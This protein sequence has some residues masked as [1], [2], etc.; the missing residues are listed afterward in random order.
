[1]TTPFYNEDHRALQESVR[2]CVQ[3]ELIPNLTKWE[4]DQWFP[5]DVFKILGQAGFLGLMIPEDLGGIGGGYRMAAAWCEEFGRVPAVGLTTAVNMHS[6]VILPA[7]ARLGS[8]AAKERWIEKGLQGQAIGA[9]A[10]TEPGAGSDLSQAKTKAVKDGDS[11]VLDGSKIFITN[12]A[13]AAFVLVLA[14]TDPSAGY[15]G[16]TTFIVDTKTPGFAVS[17]KLEK[18]GW[19]S[20]DTAE[21]SFSGV[22]VHESMVLGK[23][24]AGWTQA[25]QSLEWE[26]LML[27]LN[28]LGGSSACMEATVPYINYR[29]AF[30]KPI[31]AFGSTRDM[32]ADLWARWQAGRALTY[33]CIEMLE[34][35]T[36]CRRE[37]SLAKYAVCELAI[38][39]ADRCLQLHGGYGYT[40]E[41]IPERWLR[42]LRLNTIGGGT[43]EIMLRIAA[44]E[45][46]ELEAPR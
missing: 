19:H 38:E 44:R 27:T 4:A 30:G 28:A 42:D 11:Y 10:F 26:R 29:T 20:S 18:L 8:A 43:S 21:L 3:K 35:G 6:I 31:S 37:V 17:R 40:T 45:I 16:F 25:M 14:G 12:G 34:S 5:D 2:K 39:I 32:L 7:L 33:R 9:Y 22:R 1:M 46:A 24:G 15:D 36:R 41:Y 13:R 23:V